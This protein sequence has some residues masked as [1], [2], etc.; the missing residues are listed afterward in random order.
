MTLFLLCQ[1]QSSFYSHVIWLWFL[2]ICSIFWNIIDVIYQCCLLCVLWQ[3]S[4]K[5]IHSLPCIHTQANSAHYRGN[6]ILTNIHRFIE[7]A[8]CLG[9]QMVQDLFRNSVNIYLFLSQSVVT[10]SA[11]FCW[12]TNNSIWSYWIARILL[13]VHMLW[14]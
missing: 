7:T 4:N 13:E 3:R 9:G 14:N 5:K 10:L 1:A 2:V 8:E 12:F 11:L 6:C